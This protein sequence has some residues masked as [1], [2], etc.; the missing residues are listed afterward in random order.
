MNYFMLF[1]TFTACA[2]II[3]TTANVKNVTI[4]NL[5]TL[6][7]KLILIEL[8]SSPF[9]RTAMQ[10]YKLFVVYAN[11]YAIKHVLDAFF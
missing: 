6:I 7:R 10:R 11:V 3:A 1:S 8:L 2:I 4:I 5:F 9:F